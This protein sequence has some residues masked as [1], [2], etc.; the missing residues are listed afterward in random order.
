M[1][2]RKTLFIDRAA[3][4]LLAVLLILGGLTA[5]WW[6]TGEPVRGYQL[7]DTSDISRVAKVVDASWFAWVAALAGIV[8]ALIGIRWIAAHLT[9][10]RVKRLHL[11]GS[12][13]SGRLEVAGTKVV[14]AAAAAFAD[15]LGVRSAE[16]AVLR[17]RG[18]L[19]AHLDATIEPDADLALLARRADEV[20]AQ[21]AGALERDDLHCSVQ[22]RVAVRGRALPR[23]S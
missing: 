15:T 3:T 22:L 4:L 21:L 9:S 8:L 5:I 14:G 20:S 16:G 2:T 17:D 18:Q 11:A 6:W 10:T 19:V 23:A 7:P 12:D 13:A 1:T